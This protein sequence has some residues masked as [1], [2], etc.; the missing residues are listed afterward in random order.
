MRPCRPFSCRHVE[1][2]QRVNVSSWRV[3]AQEELR[4]EPLINSDPRRGSWAGSLFIR[5]MCLPLM[6]II[7][8]T[9]NVS[10][11]QI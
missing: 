1:F 10:F 7:A 5:V 6:S 3:I 9:S 2:R 4:V 8:F 11:S